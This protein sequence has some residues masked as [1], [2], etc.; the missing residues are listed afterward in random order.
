VRV[1]PTKLARPCSVVLVD[2]TGSAAGTVAKVAVH[3]AQTPLHH[4][5]SCYLFSR[6]GQF[7]LTRRAGSKRTGPGVR[8]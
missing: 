6:T 5:S 8:A 4:A 3:R 7:V 1:I 2:E